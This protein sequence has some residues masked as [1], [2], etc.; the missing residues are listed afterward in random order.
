MK[1]W[2][3]NTTT[4]ITCLYLSHLFIFIDF[5]SSVED[6]TSFLLPY[7]CQIENISSPHVSSAKPL[8]FINNPIHEEI[9]IVRERRQ[10]DANRKRRP[11]QRTSGRYVAQNTKELVNRESGSDKF[12]V[13]TVGRCLEANALSLL[14]YE[15][16]SQGGV[17]SSRTIPF[18]CPVDNQ[19]SLIFYTSTHSFPR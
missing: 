12:V 10:P 18:H 5:P 6:L 14:R 9:T 4:Q 7:S 16:C 15:K 19:G 3:K 13:Q 17:A 11:N 2:Y 1:F 8:H